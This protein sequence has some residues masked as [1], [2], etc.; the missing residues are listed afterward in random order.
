[1]GISTRNGLCKYQIWYQVYKKTSSNSSA[2]VCKHQDPQIC[3]K[4]IIFQN[5]SDKTILLHLKRSFS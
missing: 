2:Q 3:D 1:M 5:D 4:S